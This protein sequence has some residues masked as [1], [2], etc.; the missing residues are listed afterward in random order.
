MRAGFRYLLAAL[1]GA[2]AILALAAA[3]PTPPPPVVAVSGVAVNICGIVPTIIVAYSDGTVKSF[4]HPFADVPKVSKE[5]TVAVE[6]K[7]CQGK[8]T[9][10]PDEVF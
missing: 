7:E 9:F 1:G 6:V 3:N 2:A 10:E 5:W 4:D 8:I